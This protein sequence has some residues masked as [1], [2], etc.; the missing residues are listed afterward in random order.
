MRNRSNLLRMTGLISGLALALAACGGGSS[1]DSGASA[2]QPAGATSS[3]S[4]P[5]ASPSADPMAVARLD[6][7]YAVVKK[8]VA[9]KN[10]SDI[11]VG[12]TF[13]R[14][15]DVTPDCATG[16]CGGKVV[17]DAAES[18]QNT[19][20][21]VTYDEATHTYGFEAPLSPATCRGAD[22]KQ[23]D[24]KTSSVFTLTPTKVELSG[25]EYV[26]TKFTA[27]GTLKAVPQGA[28]L[29]KGKCKVSTAKYVYTGHAG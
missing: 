6:G 12:D 29:T 19:T 11:T 25:E 23:Y 8:V 26:V 14:T 24:L 7:L 5:A 16:P 28:A 2:S 22:R 27:V 10:F 1:S 21:T 13:K 17:I 20:Q 4:S 9:Q 18:K 3:P 15:Y